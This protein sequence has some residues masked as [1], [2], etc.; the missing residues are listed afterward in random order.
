MRPVP[1]APQFDRPPVSLGRETAGRIAY[2]AAC[3]LVGAASAGTVAA[4]RA[5]AGHPAAIASCVV[6]VPASWVVL[7]RLERWVA[8]RVVS[9][10]DPELRPRTLHDA[11]IMA[12]TTRGEPAERATWTLWFRKVPDTRMDS[13]VSRCLIA[14]VPVIACIE[15]WTLDF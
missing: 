1:P 5:V 4:S 3:L 9:I 13:L 6:A 11:V 8:R 12:R 2:G 7:T 15:R 14:C 10:H